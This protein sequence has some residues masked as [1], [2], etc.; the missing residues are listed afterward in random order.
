MP[1]ENKPDVVHEVDR[2][3]AVKPLHSLNT[4]FFRN[5]DGNSQFMTETKLAYHAHTQQQ[6]Y[7]VP[8]ES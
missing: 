8:L 5:D 7:E 1:D 3:P 6:P 4:N 2:R